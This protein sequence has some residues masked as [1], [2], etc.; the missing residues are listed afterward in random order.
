MNKIIA[1][2]AKSSTKSRR[3]FIA[4]VKS[5]PKTPGIYI[6]RNKIGR[7][8]YVGKAV[9]LK[10]RVSSYFQNKDLPTSQELRRRSDSKTA[11]LVK[12]IA[13]IDYLECG[14]EFEALVLE[15]EFIKRYKPKYNIDFKDD[16]NYAYLKITK[17]KYPRMTVVHQINDHNAE[18]LGPFIDTRAVRNILK[19]ARRIFPYCTCGL[20][21]DEVCLYY[22]IGLCQGHG[23]KYVSEKDYKKN[24]KGLKKLFAG[25]TEELRKS[26]NKEMKMA[27]QSQD[28]ELAA[29]LRD[30]LKYLGRI[31]K[32]HFIS[33]RDLSTDR[34][35]FEL[36]KALE[37]KKIPQKIE[38]FDV[39][40][41]L[42]TAAT[43]SMVV[44]RNGIASP[45]DYRR[46]QIKTI[47]GANDVAM[48]AE[49]VSRRFR[50]SEIKRKDLAFFD[51][52]DLIILDGG[53]GQLSA[54]IKKGSIP[55][56]V[57]VVALAKKREEIYTI[58][59][60]IPNNKL[61]INSKLEIPNSKFTRI[62]LPKD[63]ESLFLLQRIRDEAHR[64]AVS[65]H[66]KVRSREVFKS[67][68]DGIIGVG[69]KTRKKLLTK[70]GSIKRIKEATIVDLSRLIGEK[71]ARKIKE[72]L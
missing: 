46:F 21:A 44:F 45:H 17:E 57:K 18:Y 31:E 39:S 67:S 53:K 65:Y 51:L 43:G 7:V 70:F 9:N 5:L 63:S 26:F 33:E 47:K 22:H 66:R 38:S 30:K 2:K 28:F 64:F 4:V 49:I 68:L 24:I 58:K 8:I 36:S 6:Y 10:N 55:K 72:I 14:S 37:M 12:N 19:I 1:Q 13:K 40:N 16:K 52:P 34:A 29:N 62:L 32:S 41:I 71:L 50:L 15:A 23:E 56:S 69:P 59:H 25:K 61:Q 54:V 20:S 3:D 27:S 11:E 60:Q 42:G 35:L 48:M